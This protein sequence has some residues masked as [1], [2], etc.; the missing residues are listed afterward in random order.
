MAWEIQ[1][2]ILNQN[3]GCTALWKF[4]Y[5][6]LISANFQFQHKFPCTWKYKTKYYNLQKEYG[7]YL[8]LKEL[9]DENDFQHFDTN[10]DGKLLFDEWLTQVNK[11]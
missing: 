5:S 4:W 10:K 7:P 9:P 2:E 6:L 1:K 3:L 11:D 8:S